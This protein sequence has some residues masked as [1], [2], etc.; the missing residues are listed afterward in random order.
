MFYYMDDILL[1]AYN[2]IIFSYMLLY[3]YYKYYK[4][5][6]VICANIRINQVIV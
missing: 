3:S 1:Y 5:K 4:Y 6:L 2:L